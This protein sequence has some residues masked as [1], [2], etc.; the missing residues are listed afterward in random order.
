MPRVN[1]SLADSLETANAN[2]V[3]VRAWQIYC[4]AWAPWNANTT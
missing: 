2:P 4:G 1:R 3:P